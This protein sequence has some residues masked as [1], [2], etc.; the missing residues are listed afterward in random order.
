MAG[1]SFSFRS[2]LLV[3]SVL[4]TLG[5][6]LV[7]HAVSLLLIAHGKKVHVL[8]ISPAALAIAV[9][10]MAAGLAYVQR[11]MSPLRALR[12][13]LAS[14]QE[15][16]ERRIEG[17]YPTEV[18]PLVDDMNALLDQREEAVRRALAKAGDLAHGLKT[19]LAVLTSEAERVA[20]SGCAGHPEL[21]AALEREI[22][23]MRRQID[24]HLAHARAA[25]AGATT[26]GAR[27]S[28]RESAEGLSRTL[29]RLHADRG[30]NV[31]LRVPPAHTVRVERQE[32][33][34]ML[35]N[36]LDNAWRF[37]RSVVVVQSSLTGERVAITVDDDG[38]GIDASLRAAVLQRGVRADEAGPGS[39][40]GL[41]IVRDLAELSGGS[42]ALESSPRGGL[43]ARLELPGSSG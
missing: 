37:A 10:A 29:A 43:Q 5:L 16:R 2:R 9:V 15:G 18:Q 19:P 26:P 22:G 31:E 24:Y 38:P 21:A 8:R 3:G 4:W 27:A 20:A 12:A 11:G 25:A 13:R 42:I 36:L 6:L 14:V 30:V 39:G 28:V 17:T 1:R 35:G 7:A 41:A 40:F 32:L 23:R 34:E 33:D